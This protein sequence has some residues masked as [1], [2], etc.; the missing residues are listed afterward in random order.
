M[1]STYKK[2]AGYVK[3]PSKDARFPQGHH[4]FL[5]TPE[6]M[7]WLRET[8]L[9]GLSNRFNSALIFGNEDS[10]DTIQ[11]YLDAEPRVTDLP[12]TYV[13]S[14]RAITEKAKSSR[15]RK[16]AGVIKKQSA[17]ISSI[18]DLCAEIDRSC[19]AEFPKRDCREIGLEFH[20]RGYRDY[21]DDAPAFIEEIFRDNW[22]WGEGGA[23]KQP[24]LYN[25]ASAKKG[26]ATMTQR[27]AREF[28][29]HHAHDLFEGLMQQAEMTLVEGEL[30]EISY[31]PEARVGDL[32]D[33]YHPSGEHRTEVIEYLKSYDLVDLAHDAFEEVHDQVAAEAEKL[34]SAFEASYE[35]AAS[36]FST[37]LKLD[38]VVEEQIHQLL[39]SAEGVMDFCMS[40]AGMGVGASFA[41]RYP[42][43][44]LSEL[45]VTFDAFKPFVR[46][47]REKYAQPLFDEAGELGLLALP[48]LVEEVINEV[49]ADNAEDDEPSPVEA[50][51]RARRK[52]YRASYL[53]QPS[54]RVA[55]RRW[56]VE[57]YVDPANSDLEPDTWQD[58]CFQLFAALNKHIDQEKSRWSDIHTDGFQESS[59]PAS[60]GYQIKA[61]VDESDSEF[62]ENLAHHMVSSA[63]YEALNA[64]VETYEA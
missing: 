21:N 25:A 34:Q 42:W 13:Q 41:D 22:I 17:F 2:Q 20:N 51:T 50:S 15:P 55:V 54:R 28:M 32:I 49:L 29:Y 36:N 61:L 27:T 9:P 18:M 47:E 38:P 8:H 10:P 24:E 57:V 33:Q 53:R 46:A 48:V 4:T 64:G 52:T 12:V 56:V 37:Q 30:Q 14:R 45:G 26:S 43:N 1:S 7:E 40:D 63:R 19:G 16:A 44:E 6:D 11:V 31:D 60:D 3:A 23:V 58:L 62:V 35:K 59:G 39:T 5:N